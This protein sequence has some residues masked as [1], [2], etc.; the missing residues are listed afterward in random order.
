MLFL[1]LLVEDMFEMQRWAAQCNIVI[2]W[3]RE[4]KEDSARRLVISAYL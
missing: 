4:H 3:K 1:K 2:V